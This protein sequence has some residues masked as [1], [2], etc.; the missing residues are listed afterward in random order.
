[1][2]VS[3][4]MLVAANTHAEARERANVTLDQFPPM[5]NCTLH[6]TMLVQDDEYAIPLTVEWPDA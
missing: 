6:T 4:T 3:F 5:T 1:M 2:K